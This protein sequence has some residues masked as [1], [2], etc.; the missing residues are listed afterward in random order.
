MNDPLTPERRAELRELLDSIG[1]D[2]SEPLRDWMMGHLSGRTHAAMVDGAVNAL[3]ALLDAADER[4]RLRVWQERV[5][6]AAGIGD[7][8]EGHG[9]HLEAD[10][11]IAAE[12]MAGLLAVADAHVECAIHCDRCGETLADAWCDHCHGSGCGP[13]TAT[14]AYEECEWCAGAGKVHP[15]CADLCYAALVAERDELRAAVDTLGRIG[16]CDNCVSERSDS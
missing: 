4:D 14:G 5:A 9:V 13:G 10:P 6:L 15:G 11:D 12:H 3:P 2:N 8:V 7:E 16:P 1:Y